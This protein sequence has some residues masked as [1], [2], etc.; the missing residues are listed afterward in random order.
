MRKFRL[1]SMNHGVCTH[2]FSNSEILYNR[3]DS[4]AISLFPFNHN[5]KNTIVYKPKSAERYQHLERINIS[6]LTSSDDPLR[7]S[8][9]ARALFSPL[10][11]SGVYFSRAL[12]ALQNIHPI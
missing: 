7:P 10:Q 2:S 9:L 6:G 11:K 1:V 4:L 5:I 12:L 8:R 3:D